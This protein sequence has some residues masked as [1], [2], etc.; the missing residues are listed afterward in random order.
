MIKVSVLY[1]ETPDGRFDMD[2]YRVKHVPLVI[3]RCGGAIKRGEIEQGLADAMPGYA[4]P[5]RVT[6]H[7]IFEST[8]LM[9]AS[10]GHHLSEFLADVP[11]F[12]NIRPV[13]QI[14]EVVS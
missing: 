14:G 1:P 8:E 7:L 6:A 3:E 9:Q 5:F 11:N 10:F 12:T 13:L 2:Y 4:A